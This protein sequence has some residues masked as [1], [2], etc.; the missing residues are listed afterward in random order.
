[1]H[2]EAESVEHDIVDNPFD[3]PLV[4]RINRVAMATIAHLPSAVIDD[5]SLHFSIGGIRPEANSVARIVH[6]EIDELGVRALGIDAWPAADADSIGSGVRHLE[7]PVD[8]L[9]ARDREYGGSG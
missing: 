8:R 9:T 5:V 2:P 7:S 1:M 4:L 6:R 3:A